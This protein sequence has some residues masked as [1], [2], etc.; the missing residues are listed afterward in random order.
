MTVDHEYIYQ[1]YRDDIFAI[2]FN[3]FRNP[4][5]ADD[6]VQETFYKFC[7]SSK[8]FESEEHIR[9]W[10]I[11]VA[12]N[13]CKRVSL[14]PWRKRNCA[15]EEY[16]DT[17]YFPSEDA[18]ELFTEVMNLKKSYRQVMHLFYYEGYNIR[19]IADILGISETAVTTRLNR[20]RNEI[21]NRMRGAWQDE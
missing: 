2:G 4:N 10:L 5:D 9:N 8:A 13:E 17:L 7:K 19:E 18:G 14:S 21:K 16:A 20:A 11:R 3:Y 1:K 12:V 6:I 15:L